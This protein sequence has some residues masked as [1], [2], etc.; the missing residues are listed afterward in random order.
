M[1]QHSETLHR[2][3]YG[4]HMVLMIITDYSPKLH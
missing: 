3:I 1:L 4:F 2:P